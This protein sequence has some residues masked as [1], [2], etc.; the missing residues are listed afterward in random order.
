MF[1]CRSRFLPD[2][3]PLPCAVETCKIQ[4]WA[5]CHCCSTNLCFNHL[6]EHKDLSNF[7]LII[8]AD[9]INA[10]ADQLSTLNTDAVIGSCRLKLDKWR[11]D[12]LTV[13]NRYYVEKCQEL[14]QRCTERVDK[15]RKRINEIKTKINDLTPEQKATHEDICSLKATI[16]D[17]KRDID[18]FQA[19]GIIVDVGPLIIFQKI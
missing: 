7:Q 11:Y 18:Q 3:M 4:S 6:K 2:K 13:I 17:I 5:L 16:N 1:V 8:C 10:A 14:Q 9:E 15:H 12:C 19:K